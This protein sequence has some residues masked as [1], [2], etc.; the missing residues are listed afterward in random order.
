MFTIGVT[1]CLQLVLQYV[2]NWYYNMFTIGI[3]IGN[4]HCSKIRVI[5]NVVDS[6]TER[7]KQLQ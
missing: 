7:R 5:G 4:W 2:Y 6:I 1:I 3:T